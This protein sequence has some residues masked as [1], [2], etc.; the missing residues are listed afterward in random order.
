MRRVALLA[1]FAA[2][3]VLGACAP[4]T[5]PAGGPATAGPAPVTAPAG[6]ATEAWMS[7]MLAR[8]NA[9]RSTAGAGALQLCARLTT[10]AQAH[11]GDQAATNTMSHTG[12]NGSTMSQ[13][14]EAAGYTGWSALAEN[15]AMGYPSVSSVM[16]GWMNS[17]GHRANLLSASYLHVGLGRAAS[18]S[19]TLYWTQDFGRGGAC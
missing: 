2:C 5:A 7:D 9:E 18:A 10:A 16:D 8:I 14:I 6:G 3:L 11:S 1:T 15:V 12:S 17:P 4:G 13:R 19:G